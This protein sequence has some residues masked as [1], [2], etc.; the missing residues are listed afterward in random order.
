MSLGEWRPQT[1]IVALYHLEDVNDSGGGGFNLTNTNTVTFAAG[2]FANAAN[3]GTGDHNRNLNVSNN[4]GLTGIQD[5]SF[6]FW[7]K[8]TAE[9]ASGSY[10]IWSHE[11]TLTTAR[12]LFFDYEYNS[13]TPR[14]NI[15]VGGT[16]NTYNITLGTA[17]WYHMAYARSSNTPL[18][19]IN[20][21][22]V[23]SGSAGTGTST[24]NRLWMGGNTA[25]GSDASVML[26]EFA[27]FNTALSA[28]EIKTNYALSKGRWD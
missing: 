16:G 23:L 13:G 5:M 12:Y 10:R 28:K 17:N 19:Y 1:N 4:L 8:L 24:D 26:D 25:A 11:T 7:V 15:N 2:K 20:G 27:V 21:D 9:I 3:F 6:V 18:I 14:L 22:L